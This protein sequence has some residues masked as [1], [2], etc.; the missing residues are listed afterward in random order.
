M[1]WTTIDDAHGY[2]LERRDVEGGWLYRSLVYT[3]DRLG[4]ETIVSASI[5]FVPCESK[6][7][8]IPY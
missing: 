5:C 6:D 4:N 8:E 2:R 7:V 3:E 1:N